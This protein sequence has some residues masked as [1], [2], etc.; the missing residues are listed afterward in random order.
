MFKKIQFSNIPSKRTGMIALISIIA[1]LVSAC[2]GSTVKPSAE[3]PAAAP[4]SA[5]A[6]NSPASSDSNT[7][8]ACNLLSKEDVG[9]VLG[10]D[11]GDA[12]ES[13][14]GGVCTFTSK[15]LT[16]ILTVSSTGGIKFMS[17]TLAKLGDAAQVV[18]GLGDQ[19]FYNSDS[20]TLFALKGDAVFLFNLNNSNY[21]FPENGQ[22]LQKALAEQLIS[23]LS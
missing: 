17:E 21:Q 15:D 1:I 4:T 7:Q 3:A 2:G 19:A 12:V 11:V 20:K 16:F 14:M 8:N 5:P 23:N 13:G 10:Q 9:K 22:A 6:A 18:P